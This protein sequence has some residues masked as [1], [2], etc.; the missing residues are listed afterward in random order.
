[1]ETFSEKAR[2]MYEGLWWLRA[3]CPLEEAIAIDKE[4]LFLF[5]LQNDE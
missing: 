4:N 1:M 5:W 2:Q 3:N